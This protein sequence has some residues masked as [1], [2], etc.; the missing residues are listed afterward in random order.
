VLAQQKTIEVTSSFKP[1]LLKPNKQT[2]SP[3]PFAGDSTRSVLSYTIPSQ[4]LNFRFAPASLRPLAYEPDSLLGQSDK[5]FVKA[6]IGNLKSATLQAVA[7]I[8]N[9]ETSKGHVNGYFDGGKGKNKFQQYAQY[10]LGLNNTMSK[11]NNRFDFNAGFDRHDTYRYGYQPESLDFSKA[12]L[13][14]NYNYLHAGAAISNLSEGDAGILY[15]AGLNLHY[16]GDNNSNTE[17]LASFRA[18]ASKIIKES[19]WLSLGLDG[20]VSRVKASGESYGNNLVLLPVKAGATINKQIRLQAGIIP[21]WNNN[22]FKLLPDISAEILIK[23]GAYVL[24][25][26]FAGSYDRHNY[27]SLAEFNPW[28]TAPSFITSTRRSELFG[29][30]KG[31]VDEHFSFRLKAGMGKLKGLPLF[32]NDDEDGK[33]FNVVYD[34][35]TNVNVEGELVYQRGQSFFWSNTLKVNSY[36]NLDTYDKAFG[37]LPVDF[38]SALRMEIIDKLNVNADLYAFSGT[39]YKQKGADTDKASGGF[40]VNAGL[41]YQIKNNLGVWV[42]FRNIL[43]NEYQRWQQYRVLGFQVLGGIT[44]RM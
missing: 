3:S 32:I 22:E 4:N 24:Q 43:N 38:H 36:R 5:L 40:D 15:S 12:D 41:S 20:T 30:L 6:G 21:S 10:G 25:A 19:L 42:D 16:F 13:K 8:G 7:A 23:D 34:N 35:L 27:Q 37:W 11:G 9:G 33:S 1:S 2:F 31:V 18:N 29:A 17:T 28:I 26:G 14:L 44:F 39:W